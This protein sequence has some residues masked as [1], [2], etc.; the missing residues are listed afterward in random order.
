[1][2]IFT[3]VCEDCGSDKEELRNVNDRDRT[4]VCG[5][6]GGKMVRQVSNVAYT[7]NK[8]GDTHKA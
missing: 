5:D 6:C 8:W 3:Y 7:P 4:L 2:P 1:M